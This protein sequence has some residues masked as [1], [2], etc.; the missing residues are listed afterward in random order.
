MLTVNDAPWPWRRDLRLGELAGEIKPGADILL[1]N[2]MRADP[3]TLVQDGDVCAVIKL[4]EMPTGREVDR[5]LTARH[6]HATQERLRRAVVGVLGLGGLGSS[7]ACCLAKIGV[8]KLILADYDVVTL[9]NLH[10]QQY[11]LDQV[12]LRKTEALAAS[13]L[14]INP[15]LDVRLIPRRLRE[16]DIPRHFAAAD[17][18]A[19]CFDD[20]AMKAAALRATLLHLPGTSYVGASGVAGTGPGEA[21]VRRRLKPGVYLVGDGASEAG[22]T[23]GLFAPRVGIAAHQQANQ[24]LR[25]ILGLDEGRVKDEG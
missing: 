12:G 1:L 17:V 21:I 16:E 23:G 4:G 9:S 6:G 14:R 18:L 2:G 24:V 7:L 19:E 11:F 13:L 5:T 20:P 10:R 8:G 15:Y 25:L 22:P 3:D